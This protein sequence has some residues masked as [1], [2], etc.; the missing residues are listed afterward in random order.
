LRTGVLLNTGQWA[1]ATGWEQRNEAEQHRGEA[2]A[3][4]TGGWRLWSTGDGGALDF[5]ATAVHWTLDCGRREEGGGR[6]GDSGVPG[7]WRL[8]TTVAAED[9]ARR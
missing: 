7:D 5:G 2:E 3:Q 8:W 9:D 1:A 4:S 6:R